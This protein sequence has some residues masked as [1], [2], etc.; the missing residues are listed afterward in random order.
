[1]AIIQSVVTERREQRR[2]N[3]T[4]KRDMLDALLDVKDEF[5][6]RLTDE[7]I[8]DLLIM[9]LNAGHESSAHTTMWATLFLQ[10]NPD[11]FNKAKVCHMLYLIPLIRHFISRSSPTYKLNMCVVG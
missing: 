9:Y 7:E 6:R 5:S 4:S 8:I 2:T 3:A 11:T 1:M 10:K